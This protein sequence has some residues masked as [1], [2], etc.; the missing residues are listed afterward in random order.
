MVSNI[1][2]DERVR[3]RYISR[4]RTEIGAKGLGNH[5]GDTS[6]DLLQET[7]RVRF[8]ALTS[9]AAS[10]IGVRRSPVSALQ[11]SQQSPSEKYRVA[12]SVNNYSNYVGT[13][14]IT[15]L[16]IH[17]NLSAFCC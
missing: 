11:S 13:G 15:R 14:A 12:L 8:H 6:V 10:E 2:Q 3:P 4:S 1:S 7:Q 9:E 17:R 16:N 5:E